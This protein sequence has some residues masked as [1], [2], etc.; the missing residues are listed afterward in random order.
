LEFILAN[1]DVLIILGLVVGVIVLGF[2][3]IPY[4][5]RKGY[6]NRDDARLT[7]QLLEIVKLIVSDL[8]FE[9]KKKKEDVLLIFEISQITVRYIEQTMTFEDNKMKKEVAYNTVL[10][11]LRE[12]D[13]E[14]TENRKK[15]IKISIEAAVNQLPPTGRITKQ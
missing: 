14:I 15:L 5:K 6:L 2:G 3:L 9:D 13:I 10:E 8:K 7:A 12:L 1:I 11:I 4:F